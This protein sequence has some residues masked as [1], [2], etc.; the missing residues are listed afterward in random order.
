[1]SIQLIRN[2]IKYKDNNNHHN[3]NPKI[4]YALFSDSIMLNEDKMA[5][6][7]NL[8]ENASILVAVHFLKG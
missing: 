2:I 5:K 6:D 8:K 3:D 7:Y 1:M 4:K